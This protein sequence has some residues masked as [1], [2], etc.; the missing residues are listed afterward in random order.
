MK[1]LLIASAIWSAATQLLASGFM[2][3]EQGAS[4]VGTALAGATSNANRDASC[5]FWNP[6]AAFF[7]ESDTKIDVGMNFIMPVF[8]FNGSATHPGGSPVSGNDGGN[9]GTLNIVPNFYATHKLSEDF[10]FT[11]SVTAPAGLTT[12]YDS[13][14]VGRAHGIRSDLAT[15]D[16]NPSIAYKVND[17]FF[18]SVGASAQYINAELTQSGYGNTFSRVDGHSWSGG[19]NLGFTVKYCETGRFSVGYRSQVNQSISG[20]LTVPSIPALSGDVDCELT[21]PNVVNV[22]VYQRLWGDLEDFAVMLDFAWTQ[23]SSFDSL[24]I[25]YTNGAMASHTVE[26]WEDTCRV[27][28][29]AHYYLDDDITLRLGVAYD[30]SPIVSTAYRT[31]RIPDSDRVWLSCGLGYKFGNFNIDVAYAFI[32]FPSVGTTY[33]DPTK[34]DLSGEFYGH[35][36]IVSAQIGYSF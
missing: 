16:I 31:P 5:A 18:V 6:S 12:D 8:K 4:N 2:V 33:S 34:G 9:A 23:W 36:H 30:E 13:N 11:F 10:I 1:K 19:F 24:D 32:F 29:G 21:I 7:V 27:S 25:K 28:F 3:I 17:W 22:G 35:S 20:G 14:Y 26:N 15:I